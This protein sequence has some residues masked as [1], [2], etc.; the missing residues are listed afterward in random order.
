MLW[1]RFWIGLPNPCQHPWSRPTDHR[2]TA[3]SWTLSTLPK[4][5]RRRQRCKCRWTIPRKMLRH[6]RRLPWRAALPTRRLVP[7]RP[8]PRI[9]HMALTAVTRHGKGLRASFSGRSGRLYLFPE[10]E[11]VRVKAARGQRTEAPLLLR[12]PVLPLPRRPTGEAGGRTPP[13]SRDSSSSVLNSRPPL[14]LPQ[15]GYQWEGHHRSSLRNRQRHQGGTL[16]TPMTF[17]P[18]L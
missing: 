12:V 16:L 15:I 6:H 9:I 1:W 3:R 14:L 7:G 2:H 18:S 11:G 5:A 13:S 17:L 10:M 4:R 8:L